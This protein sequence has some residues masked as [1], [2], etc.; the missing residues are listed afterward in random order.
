VSIS[1]PEVRENEA[2]PD[3][4]MIYGDIRRVIGIPLVNLIY[5]HFATLPGVLPWV[6]SHIRTPIAVGAVER[7]RE[8]LVA[9]LMTGLKY[10]QFRWVGL[11]RDGLRLADL[12]EI[13]QLME[14]YNRGNA[15]NLIVL[16]AVRL[17]LDHVRGRQ[18]SSY[19]SI[20]CSPPLSLATVKIPA[21][22]KLTELSPETRALVET[23]HAAH[24]SADDGIIPSLYLHLAHWPGFLGVASQILEPLF[25]GKE[26]QRQ[27]DAAIR[28][29]ETAALRVFGNLGG[30]P[31]PADKVEAVRWALSRFTR[32]VIPELLVV[33]LTLTSALPAD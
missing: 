30:A 10:E 7:D 17:H 27:R 16:T 12:H 28:A 26:L 11:A 8:D 25:T 19:D 3:V 5:R 33:G 23:L 6:W 14:V 1:F 24:G 9:N 4:A 13:R 20:S 2:T 22:P 15:T 32:H 18:P 31:L 29:S 21:L